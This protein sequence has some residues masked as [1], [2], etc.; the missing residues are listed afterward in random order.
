MLYLFSDFPVKF[1]CNRNILTYKTPKE[2]SLKLQVSSFSFTQNLKVVYT[3]KIKPHQK[4]SGCKWAEWIQLPSE[5]CSDLLRKN[6]KTAPFGGQTGPNLWY[7]IHVR[8]PISSY[9]LKQKLLEFDHPGDWKA[10]ANFGA[11]F[12]EYF[13][14]SRSIHNGQSPMF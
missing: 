13:I 10:L 8:K 7:H 9:L 3:T 11:F 1:G 4:S 6:S 5:I 2:P 12:L 14:R